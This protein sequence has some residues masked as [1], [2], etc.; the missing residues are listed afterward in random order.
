MKAYSEDLR[1]KIVEAVPLAHSLWGQ[2]FHV[3]ARESSYLESTA[4]EVTPVRRR[5]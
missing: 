5:D 3:Y 4:H 2:I 1:E